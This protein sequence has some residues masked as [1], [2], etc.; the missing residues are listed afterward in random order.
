MQKGSSA[1]HSC[2]IEKIAD[3][4]TESLG[5]IMNDWLSRSEIGGDIEHTNFSIG[6]KDDIDD[7]C[8]EYGYG[9]EGKSR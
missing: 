7:L 5:D 3:R 2:Q 6:M 9:E 1:K 8:D 4:D